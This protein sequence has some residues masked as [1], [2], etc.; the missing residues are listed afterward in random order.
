M[1]FNH[2]IISL[3][4][5]PAEFLQLSP[6]GKVPLL[7]RDDGSVV[8][9]SI[10]VSRCVA[11]EFSD[12]VLLPPGDAAAIDAFVRHW[13]NRCEPAYYNVL[14]ADSEFQASAALSGLLE[15]LSQVNEQ[16]QVTRDAF[17]LGSQFSH[18]ECV[19][20][21]W[22]QRML[23]ML[24]YWRNMDIL[25]ECEQRGLSCTARWLR[26]VAARPS[27]I[28]TAC[29]EAEMVRASKLY[30]VDYASPGS[31]GEAAL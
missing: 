10:D 9:E 2:E 24:P 27:V 5:K 7:Q 28:E 19:A 8:T 21:P 23:L 25:D 1:P 14:K 20:A 4:N 15:T 16:L 29:E 30:Y 18:A 13:T 6:T 31:P 22:V 3:K 12:G 17:L 26:A 11:T